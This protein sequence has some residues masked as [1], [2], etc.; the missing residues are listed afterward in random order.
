MFKSHWDFHIAGSGCVP[1]SPT[2]I[3]LLFYP[4]I[5][6][7]RKQLT[8][9][10]Y[11]RRR[12]AFK[13]ST[14]RQIVFSLYQQHNCFSFT[15]HWQNQEQSNL[16]LPQLSECLSMC[17][18]SAP[19]WL[20]STITVF[21]WWCFAFWKIEFYILAFKNPVH[22]VL[23]LPALVHIEAVAKCQLDVSVVWLLQFWHSAMQKALV[24]TGNSFLTSPHTLFCWKF[25]AVVFFP[26]PE[27]LQMN[28]QHKSDSP[29]ES[30]K[31]PS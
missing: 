11:L 20:K 26:S 28:H 9:Q 10:N 19:R 24:H 12:A 27:A 8:E 7:R 13:V 25:F 29:Y 17:S 6:L 14:G 1:L 16:R 5:R 15:S 31:Q 21:C 30:F 3:L 4:S 2:L 18:P 23:S 22:S